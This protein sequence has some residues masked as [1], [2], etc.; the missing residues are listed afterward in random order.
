MDPTVKG[1]ALSLCVLSLGLGVLQIRDAL[2]LGSVSNLA[3]QE[4]KAMLTGDGPLALS[5]IASTNGL[6]GKT[7]WQGAKSAH[8]VVDYEPKVESKLT[9][10]CT[11][12]ELLR[13]ALEVEPTNSRYLVSWSNVRQLIGG[14]ICPGS[15]AALPKYNAAL[16]QAIERDP[17]NPRVL[18]SAGLV[19][20]WDADGNNARDVF[21]RYLLAGESPSAP[22]M[23]A[24]LSSISSVE[25][26]K[27]VVP[28]RFPQVVQWSGPLLRKFSGNTNANST[29]S[30][31]Q[32]TALEGSRV[33]LQNKSITSAIFK[34]RLVQL[35]LVVASDHVRRAVD[36]ALGDIYGDHIDKRL[37]LLFSRL[38]QMTELSLIRGRTDGD[39]RPHRSSLTAWGNDDVVE[40]D[41]RYQSV[42]ALIPGKRT[43]K[44]FILMGSAGLA[45][46]EPSLIK[47]LA[48]TDN[49]SWTELTDR[50]GIFPYQFEDRPMLMIDV[51]GVGDSY[52]YWKVNFG[53]GSDEPRITNNLSE[54][55]RIYG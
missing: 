47:V 3:E 19:H 13:R 40:F 11:E 20:L 17:N 18:Y 54:L 38:S 52:K 35:R 27:V 10:A 41:G 21:R 25:D 24:I 28:A 2:F 48:S 23:E 1:A 4:P 30:E 7:Y 36:A 37:G 9:L 26:I 34:E 6:A 15:S 16:D 55:L 39:S 22:Q 5:E 32:E 49:S 14:N 43:P 8:A 53:S 33:E 46:R 31:L 29:I 45:A 44:V 12:L 42:G 50:S 51:A